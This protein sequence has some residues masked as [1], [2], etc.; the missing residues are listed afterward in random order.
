M[1]HNVAADAAD[2]APSTASAIG[3]AAPGAWPL[4]WTRAAVL[5]AAKAAPSC[6]ASF[7]A[8]YKRPRTHAPPYGKRRKGKTKKRKGLCCRTH[9]GGQEKPGSPGVFVPT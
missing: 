5:A 8:F 7:M 4:R 1:P 9:N 2:R 3:V 6:K